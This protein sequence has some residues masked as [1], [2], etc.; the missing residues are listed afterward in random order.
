MA[1]EADLPLSRPLRVLLLEDSDIDTELL[2][3]HLY[4]AGIECQITLA[5]TRQEFHAALQ[6]A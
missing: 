4:K 1:V 2:I 5:T 6:P 3:G